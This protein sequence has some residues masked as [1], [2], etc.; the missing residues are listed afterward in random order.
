[1]RGSP[2]G[3]SHECCGAQLL[4]AAPVHCSLAVPRHCEPPCLVAVHTTVP[5]PLPLHQTVESALVVCGPPSLHAALPR[6]CAHDSGGAAAAAA[7]VHR[8]LLSPPSLQAALSG[9]CAHD[10][11]RA[12]AAAR[13]GCASPAAV[14]RVRHVGAVNAVLASPQHERER[15]VSRHHSSS[16]GTATR[17][18]SLH[19]TLVHR[20]RMHWLIGSSRRTLKMQFPPPRPGAAD[21]CA[22]TSSLHMLP[23]HSPSPRPAAPLRP[24]R[25]QH[26]S[27]NP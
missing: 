2:R 19:A 11:G 25:R 4:L 9:R 3:S 21:I 7:P 1:M 26:Q 27:T 24:P 20:C 18:Q 15:H 14:L 5:G 22:S 10:C 6:G 16:H 13:N 8:S 23:L 17:L 12:A